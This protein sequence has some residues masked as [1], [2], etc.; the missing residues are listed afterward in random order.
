MP[1]WTKKPWFESK[2]LWFNIV[3]LVIV[4]GDLIIDGGLVNEST[5]AWIIVGMGMGNAILRM[6]TSKA[7]RVGK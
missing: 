4:F 7:I 5:G 3:T 1:S 6:V 2:T